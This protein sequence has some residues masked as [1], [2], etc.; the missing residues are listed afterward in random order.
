[1]PETN[2]TD[3]YEAWRADPE[4][5]AQPTLQDAFV[6]GFAQCMEWLSGQPRQRQEPSAGG[7]DRP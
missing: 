2:I 1:M 3:R 7:G 4:T 6:E 5:P